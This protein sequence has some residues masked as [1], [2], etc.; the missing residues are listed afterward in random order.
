MAVNFVYTY[1]PHAFSKAVSLTLHKD[2]FT[3]QQEEKAEVSVQLK[4]VQMLRF[5]TMDLGGGKQN[6]GCEIITN[7]KQSY[8]IQSYDIHSIAKRNDQAN[9]YRPLIINL[10]ERVQQCN[11][12]VEFIT[13]LKPSL[14]KVYKGIFIFSIITIAF[15]TFLL[16]TD[17]ENTTQLFVRLIF[18]SAM[19]FSFYNFMK[20][21]KPGKL[22]SNEVPKEFLP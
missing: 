9:H 11:Q 4:D 16:V 15:V 17:A 3:F 20:K 10:M 7:D 22:P 2:Y 13:G 6:Y 1:K 5:Y 21:N 18:V 12:Q 8:K 14:H 19:T